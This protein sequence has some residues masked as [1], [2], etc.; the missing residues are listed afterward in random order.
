MLLLKLS[1]AI[2]I[3]QTTV[4]VACQPESQKTRKKERKKENILTEPGGTV[5]ARETTGS[6][7]DL[8]RACELNVSTD[9]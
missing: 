8:T 4:F 1:F 3:N 7:A 2:R 9:N 6:D 5:L